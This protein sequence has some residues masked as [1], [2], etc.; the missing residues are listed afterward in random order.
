MIY[1]I[2]SDISMLRAFELILESAAMEYESFQ[3]TDSFQANVKP[4][5]ND[6]II[7]DLSFAGKVGCE[8]LRKICQY[9]IQIPI[10]VVTVFDDNQLQECC[11]QNGVKA[12]IRKPV[13]GEALIDLIKYCLP[14]KNLL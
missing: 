7:L 9:R 2:D 6:L 1:L 14:F 13:D 8:Q 11:R 4:T 5:V 12:I 3:N 10:I